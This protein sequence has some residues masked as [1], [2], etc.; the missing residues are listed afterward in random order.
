M[1]KDVKTI[2]DKAMSMTQ[3]QRA[4]IAERLI[5]SLETTI[6]SDVEKEW[7]LEIQ[8][9]MADAGREDIVFMNWDEAKKR[10]WGEN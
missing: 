4:F 1:N 3:Q 2:L 10:L 5:D 9:R 8:K 6:D 7:Q